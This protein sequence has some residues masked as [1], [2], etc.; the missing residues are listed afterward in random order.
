MKKSFLLLSLLLLFQSCSD[1]PSKNQ[2]AVA[3]KY[4]QNYTQQPIS[5]VSPVEIQLK[6]KLPQYTTDQKL[7]SEFIKIGPEVKGDLYIKNGNRL[8][9]IPKQKLQPA[10]TY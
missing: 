6:E 7:P 1:D 9:F 10:T 5:V 8:R 3:S 2:T 4:I